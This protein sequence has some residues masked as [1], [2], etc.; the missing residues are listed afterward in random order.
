VLLTVQQ[1][2]RGPRATH[3]RCENPEF[4]RSIRTLRQA[5]VVSLLRTVLHR[6]VDVSVYGKLPQPLNA[7]KLS[8]L[9]LSG[10]PRNVKIN[11]SSQNMGSLFVTTPD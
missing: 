5:W 6:M 10:F 2:D 4:Q 11:R 3:V 7:Y 1:I 8:S 9:S